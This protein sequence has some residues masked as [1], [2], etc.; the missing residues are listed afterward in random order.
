[1]ELREIGVYLV[2]GSAVGHTSWHL[3]TSQTLTGSVFDLDQL[4]HQPR[5]TFSGS[6][7]GSH[8]EAIQ[9]SF[10]QAGHHELGSS[11]LCVLGLK[12]DIAEKL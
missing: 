1:M 11:D 8:S 2:R 10:L 6:V 7:D 9:T 5:V 3:T 12:T 4:R